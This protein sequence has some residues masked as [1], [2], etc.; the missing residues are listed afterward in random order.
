[1][2][3]RNSGCY[4]EALHLRPQ[5]Q[6]ASARVV[7]GLDPV[8]I[9]RQ[10]QL[11]APPVPN[12]ESEHAVE[13][14]YGALTPFEV[15]MQDDFGG[16]LRAESVSEALELGRQL[17]EVVDLTV[18]GERHRAVR[19]EHRLMP[20]GSWI[21]DRKP[22]VAEPCRA[23]DVV[24]VVV[25]SAVGNRLGH[26][27]QELGRRRRAIVV[28]YARDPAHGLGVI[29]RAESL[30]PLLDRAAQVVLAP[31]DHA[32]QPLA[33]VDL[34]VEASQLLRQLC[35]AHPM[36]QPIR[37]PRGSSWGRD[38]TQSGRAVLRPARGW[39]S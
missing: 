34:S 25:G 38:P 23:V 20:V 4:Q 18:V 19:C 14:L 17:L 30:D 16:G 13:A 32:A 36:G 5:R 37:A 6:R 7:E 24:S 39:S 33:V 2:R 35:A 29:G 26:P 15:G 27:M 10:K 21:D 22:A 28:Q 1:M 11:T 8:T 9:T 12:G 31:L 3:T